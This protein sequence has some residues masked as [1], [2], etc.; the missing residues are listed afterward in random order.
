[1]LTGYELSIVEV[2][3]C[4]PQ[5]APAIE[6]LMRIK[7]GTLDSLHIDEFDEHAKVCFEAL[8]ILRVENDVETLRSLRL[9]S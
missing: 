5:D 3:G 6:E 2:T 7:F 9:T 4:E 1:V 8:K